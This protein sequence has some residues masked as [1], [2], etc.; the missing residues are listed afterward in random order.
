[1]DASSPTTTS[2]VDLARRVEVGVGDRGPSTDE[3]DA[4]RL[5]D[6]LVRRSDVG[7]RQAVTTA[8]SRGV[9]WQAIGGALGV[10]RQ[11][12]FKRFDL[13]DQRA[14][15]EAY[16]VDLCQRTAGVFR[17]LDA[18]AYDD[19]R[20]LMTYACA[21]ALTRRKLMSVWAAVTASTGRLRTTGNPI[22]L[23]PEGATVVARFL[24]RHLSTGAIVQVALSHEAGEWIGRVAYNG[25]G[26]I[27]GVLIAPLGARD[28]AF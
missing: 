10:S 9:S 6:E 2:L 12:A 7:L 18:D 5:A 3:L 21:R 20:A 27:T 11:A 16:G 19:V 13:N 4:I 28:L 24:N 8:R 15:P 25:A 26:R 14:E 22:V 1:M 23:T 17:S